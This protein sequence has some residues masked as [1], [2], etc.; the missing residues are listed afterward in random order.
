MLPHK[1]ITVRSEFSFGALDNLAALP[2]YRL[3]AP[4]DF[5]IDASTQI[6][7]VERVQLPA[8]LA[9]V[10]NK[11]FVAPVLL[12]VGGR[13]GRKTGQLVL[14]ESN[15]LHLHMLAVVFFKSLRQ[16]LLG[17]AQTARIPVADVKHDQRPTVVTLRDVVD[18]GGAREPV[19]NPEPY[20]VFIEHGL[21]NATYGAL[22]GPDFEPYRLLIPVIA[23]VAV[24]HAARILFGVVPACDALQLAALIDDPLPR[25]YVLLAGFLEQAINPLHF[26]PPHRRDQTGGE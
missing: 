1:A 25:D 23:P 3:D 17:H 18:G 22:L 16:I 6:I 10:P 2:S 21:K 14:R 20:A 5:H 12:F 4:C 7:R 13:E 15:P 26:T 24:D 19:H 11:P 8:A 9:V